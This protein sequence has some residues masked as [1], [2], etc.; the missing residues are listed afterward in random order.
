MLGARIGTRASEL[1]DPGLSK[2][3]FIGICRRGSLFVGKPFRGIIEAGS[4]FWCQGEGGENSFGSSWSKPNPTKRPT[5]P[6]PKDRELEGCW[7]GFP[8]HVPSGNLMLGSFQHRCPLIENR[9]H[10]FCVSFFLLFS[11]V[12]V[13]FTRAIDFTERTLGFKGTTS[14]LQPWQG[15]SDVTPVGGPPKKPRPERRHMQPTSDPFPAFSRLQTRLHLCSPGLNHA[16]KWLKDS[17]T[18]GSLIF[19]KGGPN[20]EGDLSHG[21]A[22]ERPIVLLEDLLT[23]AFQASGRQEY[24]WCRLPAFDRDIKKW[25]PDVSPQRGWSFLVSP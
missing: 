24:A 5:R 8:S 3:G 4:I 22:K 6:T 11:V 2:E 1:R 23:T 25:V 7:F 13:S 20:V 15:K 16:S 10:W 18:G 14:K 12:Y 19:E 21:F 9:W 17:Y